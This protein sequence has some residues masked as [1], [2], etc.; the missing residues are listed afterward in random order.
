MP[1]YIFGLTPSSCNHSF[2]VL[3]VLYLYLGCALNIAAEVYS[4]T[5]SPFCIVY[6]LLFLL[7]RVSLGYKFQYDKSDGFMVTDDKT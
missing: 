2:T 7:K 6:G 4:N 3:F 5:C 1:I